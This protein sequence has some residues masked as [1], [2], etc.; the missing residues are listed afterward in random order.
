MPSWKFYFFPSNKET[1]RKLSLTRFVWLVKTYCFPPSILSF[2]PHPILFPLHYFSPSI[3]FLLQ[4]ISIPVMQKNWRGFIFRSPVVFAWRVFVWPETI[5][6]TSRKTRIRKQEKGLLKPCNYLH[7][8]FCY[9][10]PCFHDTI[11]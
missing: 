2:L 7:Y 10:C 6:V 5:F 3:V 11:T 1:L 4:T 8:V 9:P